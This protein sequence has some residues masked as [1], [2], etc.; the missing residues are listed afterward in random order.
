[1]C[2]ALAAAD[3]SQYENEL[4]FYHGDHLSS[5]QM[6]TDINA[7]VTQQV[8]YAPFGEVISESNA[9]WHNGQIPDYMFN[10]KE[11]DEENGMYYYSARYYAPPVFTSRDPLFEKYPFMSPYAYCANNPL[12]YIDPDGKE[13]IDAEWGGTAWQNIEFNNDNFRND[14]GGDY[15]KGGSSQ[16][17]PQ[18]QPK[19]QTLQQQLAS[20]LGTTKIGESISGKELGKALGIEQLS[21][22][23]NKITKTD[24]TTFDVTRTMA[25]L[26]V[27]KDSPMKIEKTNIDING[28]E[29]SVY[30]IQIQY[31][32][33]ALER[34][35]LPD[36][37]LRNN[38]IFFYG[39]DGKL[40]KGSFPE[41]GKK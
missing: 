40:Q 3:T 15:Q 21:L 11:L 19:Q 35:A 24:E 34:K 29:T 17:Q 38:D 25:G 2:N 32:D 31:R 4:F 6:V 39:D 7:N 23:I 37:Y 33:I 10:A 9:Y 8:L 30:R 27:L 13:T 36:F 18:Q 22:M 1:L 5:T 12:R 20:T 41:K 16:Q 28:K 26:A 14:F